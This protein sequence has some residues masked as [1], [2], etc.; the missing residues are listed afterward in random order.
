[1]PV[2]LRLIEHV[3]VGV[4]RVVDALLDADISRHT[5][6]PLKQR[7]CG[8]DARDAAIAVGD[9]MDREEIEDE[10]A[11]EDQWMRELVVERVVVA[12]DEFAQ[13]EFGLSPRRRIKEDDPH[14]VL[15]TGDDPVVVGLQ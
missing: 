9:G 13:Q 15:V 11:D 8:E 1:V 2:A 6:S 3:V 10:G 7:L 4:L 14:P 5:I 12:R